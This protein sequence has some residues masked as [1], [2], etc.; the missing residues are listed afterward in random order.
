MEVRDSFIDVNSC[1]LCCFRC[2]VCTTRMLFF[3]RISRVVLPA[4]AT[5]PQHAHQKP[6]DCEVR[7]LPYSLL[8]MVKIPR[9]SVLGLVERTNV[10]T[11]SIYG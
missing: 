1:Y 8:S 11:K 2:D 6:I 9:V 10:R 7:V 4:K 5:A 3:C